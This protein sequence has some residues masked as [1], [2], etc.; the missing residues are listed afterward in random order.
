MINVLS[1][2]CDMNSEFEHSRPLL[3]FWVTKDFLYVSPDILKG[4]GP[5]LSDWFYTAKLI[6]LFHFPSTFLRE[7]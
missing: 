4:K 5:I 6:P 3:I 1:V 2:M 7:P